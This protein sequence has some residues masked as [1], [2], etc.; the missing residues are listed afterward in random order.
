MTQL[1]LF[2]TQHGSWVR[3][4][5]RPTRVLTEGMCVLCRVRMLLPHKCPIPPPPFRS[6]PHPVKIGDD[7]GVLL[8]G[9]EAPPSFWK[10]QN[11]PKLPRRSPG[12][13][14]G[15]SL[16]VD[17]KSNPQ[18]PWQFHYRFPEVPQRLPGSSRHL[19]GPRGQPLSL[20]SLT[21]SPDSLDAPLIKRARTSC[22]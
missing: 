6:H 13:F 20:G 3:T 10:V 7:F 12:N 11:F 5:T 21:P 15:T 16:T 17:L 8:G 14:P 2:L 4:F 1:A 19:P 18:I 22:P 9:S